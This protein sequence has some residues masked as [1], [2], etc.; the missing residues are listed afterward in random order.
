M[1]KIIRKLLTKE[2]ET[3]EVSGV[4]I[5]MTPA[6]F[7]KFNQLLDTIPSTF[8]VDLSNGHSGSVNGILS[9]NNVE[10]HIS[11]YDGG[12]ASIFLGN[13]KS[14]QIT[15]PK[16][17]RPHE[18]LLPKLQAIVNNVNT[19]IIN[20]FLAGDPYSVSAPAELLQQQVDDISV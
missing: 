9:R 1:L 2:E 20:Q 11:F 7:T 19:N 5:E 10:L 8:E 12:T 16:A 15:I 18:T 4:T 3:M 14:G 6:Q 17:L 13:Y